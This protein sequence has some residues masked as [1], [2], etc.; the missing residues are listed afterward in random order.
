MNENKITGL[1]VVDEASLLVNVNSITDLLAANLSDNK[2][3][4]ADFH[5]SPLMDG[6][7]ELHGLLTPD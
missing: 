4:Q 1:P 6:L 3:G 2:F 7:A 5:T